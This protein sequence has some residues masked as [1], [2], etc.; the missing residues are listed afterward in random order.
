[1]YES[2]A[3]AS[4]YFFFSMYIYVEKF[5]M[6][7]TRLSL[8]LLIV[9]AFMLIIGFLLGFFVLFAWGLQGFPIPKILF[10]NYGVFRWI[11]ILKIS[12][13]KN[14][15]L[16]ICLIQK[17]AETRVHYPSNKTINTPK[18]SQATTPTP[19]IEISSI[20]SPPIEKIHQTSERERK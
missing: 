11:L 2:K 13:L 19:K 4:M 7:I 10:E 17:H 6:V 5:S 16:K 3:L 15:V 8:K 9:A 14:R 1:M 18:P 20:T 12:Q